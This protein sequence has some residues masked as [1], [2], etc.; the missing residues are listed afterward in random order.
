MLSNFMQNDCVGVE[1]IFEND[2]EHA[3][4]TG[5]YFFCVPDVF[6]FVLMVPG[7]GAVNGLP[8]SPQPLA[9]VPQSLSEDRFDGS[10]LCRSNVD[11]QVSVDRHGCDQLPNQLFRRQKVL[12]FR[13]IAVAPT[14]LIDRHRVL[15]LMLLQHAGVETVGT[16]VNITM[17]A[18]R[19]DAPTIVR[20][21]SFSHGAAVV[22]PREEFLSLPI[23]VGRLPVAVAPNNLRIKALDYFDKLRPHFEVHVSLFEEAVQLI[24]LVHSIEPLEERV[25]NS[26]LHGL[27]AHRLRQFF[28]DVAVGT[29]VH[30][31]PAERIRRWIKRVT[32]VVLG[33]ENDIL[34]TGV[35]EDL[36]PLGGVEEFASKIRR[37]V[38]PKRKCVSLKKV[39]ELLKTFCKP[40]K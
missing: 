6:A 22:K 18:V 21:N 11:Q 35:S 20:H 31:V 33:R 14:F 4:P 32:L 8:V 7:S 15:K 10:I 36:G 13:V 39:N 19:S 17:L 29:D 25:I 23:L 40:D 34:R 24:V 37:E 2:N 16:S 9:H 26:K 12:Q 30:R 5:A 3:N 38:L 28:E 27:L 1:R